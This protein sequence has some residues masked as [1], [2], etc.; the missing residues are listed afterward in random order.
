MTGD[1]ALGIVQARASQV[2]ILGENQP[3]GLVDDPCHGHFQ[4]GT[5]QQ[6]AATIVQLCS[7]DADVLLTGDFPAP[8]VC[9]LHLEIQRFCAAHQAAAAVIQLVAGQAQFALSHKLATLLLKHANGGEQIT[10]AGDATLAVGDCVG[11]QTDHAAGAEQT[12]LIAQLAGAEVQRSHTV[13]QAIAIV[14]QGQ[15]HQHVLVGADHAVA[16]VQGSAAQGQEVLPGQTTASVVE[17]VDEK[18]HGTLGQNTAAV[19]VI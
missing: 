13:Q 1:A 14:Q 15:A 9:G 11:A 12:A 7:V 10:L 8:V 2:D 4:R 18:F 16:V 5:G 3:A 19:L 17:A 6:L